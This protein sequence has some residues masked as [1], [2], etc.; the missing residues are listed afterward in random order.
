MLIFLAAA[1]GA[2]SGKN[3]NN[4]HLSDIFLTLRLATNFTSETLFCLSVHVFGSSLNGDIPNR[5]RSTRSILT[6]PLFHECDYNHVHVF[7]APCNIL[8][9]LLF[10]PFLMFSFIPGTLARVNCNSGSV[11]PRI[12][13]LLFVYNTQNILQTCTETEWERKSSL[14]IVLHYKSKWLNRGEDD[15]SGLLMWTKHFTSDCLGRI[16]TVFTCLLT[17]KVL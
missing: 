13:L 15:E 9:L 7:G 11:L 12:S 1:W 8:A 3:L 14:L 17:G 2:E 6:P 4:L 16:C 10:W 5:R